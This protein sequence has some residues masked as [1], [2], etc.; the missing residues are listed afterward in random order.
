ME[1]RKRVVSE[2]LSG[3]C[4]TPP[5]VVREYRV[6][7]AYH[8]SPVDVAQWDDDDVEFW[9]WMNSAMRIFDRPAAQSTQRRLGKKRK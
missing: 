9:D 3:A 1:D 8:I 7:R 6:A 4:S 2:Y 5:R